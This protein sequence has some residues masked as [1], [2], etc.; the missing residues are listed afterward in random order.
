MPDPVVARVNELTTTAL[1]S[2]SMLALAAGAGWGA[3][4]SWGPAWGPAMGGLALALMS[5][6]VQHR[7]RTKEPK[8]VDEPADKPLPGA[9]DPGPVHVLGR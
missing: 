8:P 3:W 7:S 9:S 6:Y 5:S 1:D 4:I 2:L